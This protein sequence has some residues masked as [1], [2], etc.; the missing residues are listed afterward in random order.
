MPFIDLPDRIPGLRAQAR[1]DKP[2]YQF[3]NIAADEAELFLYDEIGGWGTLAEDFIAELK[4][5]TAP[6]LRVRVSSPGGSVFEGIALANALRAHPADVTVQVDGIAASIASVIAMAGDRVV[7]QPQAMIMIHDAAGVC[8]GNA[9][10]MQDMAAL[11][12]KI[13]GN[14]ADAY[15]EKAGGTRDE[16]RTQM[17][18]ESWFTAEEAVAAGLADELLPARK[19]QAQPEEAEPA[20][21]QFDLT[22]YGYHGPAKA[23]TPNPTPPPVVDATEHLA[24][25]PT[26]VISIADLLDEDAVARLRAAVQPPAEPAAVVDPEPAEP[27]VPAEPAPV[28]VAEPLEP[29]APAEPA[30]VDDWAATVAHLTD[31]QPD[32]WAAAVARFTHSTSASSAATEAA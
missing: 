2:W 8:M 11:L 31:P 6:S 29:E 12:D 21:R 27:E 30:A 7:V 14:I 16:W 4:A 9:Q 32:P 1:S 26:L 18:A 17:R 13:S 20:M 5:V 15:S 28:V 25:Q 24:G 22:A 19:Q 23:E 3:R 10:D